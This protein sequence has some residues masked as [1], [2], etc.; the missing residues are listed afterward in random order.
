VED[1]ERY[2]MIQ[3]PSKSLSHSQWDDVIRSLSEIELTLVVII[4]LMESKGQV[5]SYS[6]EQVYASYKT[7]VIRELE[8]NPYDRE[9]MERVMQRMEDCGIIH[10]TEG[11]DKIQRHY[12]LNLIPSQ[13]HSLPVLCRDTCPDQVLHWMRR[14]CN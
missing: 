4:Y 14:H 12:R 7:A 3:K 9:I 1:F 11:R 10:S 2:S 13:V 6:V 8:G 5:V